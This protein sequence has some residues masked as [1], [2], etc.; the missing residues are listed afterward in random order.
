MDRRIMRDSFILKLKLE[1][2][3]SKHLGVSGGRPDK[4]IPYGMC[5]Q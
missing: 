3:F 4:K 2:H 1:E 5:I